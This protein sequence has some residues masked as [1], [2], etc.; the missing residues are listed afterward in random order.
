MRAYI[1]YTFQANA[2]IATEKT[3]CIVDFCEE[4]TDTARNLESIPRDKRGP[5]YGIPLS[6]KECF[7]VKGYDHTAG[8]AKEIGKPSL[9]DGSFVRVCFLSLWFVRM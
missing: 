9:E 7:H 4:S 1:D 3:N 6:I 2:I 8:L 5:L